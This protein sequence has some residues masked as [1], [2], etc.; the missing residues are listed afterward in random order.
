MI[1]YKPKEKVHNG[2]IFS[3]VTKFMYGLPQ[4]VRISHDVLVQQLAPYVYHP[5]KT[6]PGIWTHNIRSI[7]FTL[8]VDDLGMNYSGK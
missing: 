3:I 7:N 2:Y 4:E 5:T 6:T 1:H 8:V